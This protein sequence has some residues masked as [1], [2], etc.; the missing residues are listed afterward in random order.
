METRNLES[1]LHPVLSVVD[2][3]DR[4]LFCHMIGVRRTPGLGSA[5]FGFGRRYSRPRHDIAHDNTV[6]SSGKVH[7]DRLAVSTFARFLAIGL[8]KCGIVIG[9]LCCTRT[10][11]SIVLVKLKESETKWT[12][13]D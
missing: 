2:I 6:Y 13:L 4:D 8:L 3:K 7:W 12:W 10:P 5:Y 1:F 9:R 11:Y